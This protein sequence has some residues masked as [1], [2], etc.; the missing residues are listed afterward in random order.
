[1]QQ[2][3]QNSR[4]VAQLKV[5]LNKAAQG[6]PRGATSAATHHASQSKDVQSTF[7]YPFFYLHA[8]LPT[9]GLPSIAHS[10]SLNE[11]ELIQK[12]AK[13]KTTQLV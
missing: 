3:C 6:A 2:P 11:R 5:Y 8:Y 4:A 10:A 13:T 12:A 9:D 7:V 1:M